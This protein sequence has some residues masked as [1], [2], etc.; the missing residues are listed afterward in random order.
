ML[1]I[2]RGR[3]HGLPSYNQT[4]SDLGLT[5][6]SSFADITSDTDLQTALASVYS[7]VNDV[8]VWVGGIAEDHLAGSSVGL[9]INTIL[10][11]QFE[12]LRD[13]DRFWFENDPFFTGDPQLLAELQATTL[14][15]IILRNTNIASLQSN[16]F[17]IPEPTT[18][19]L[20]GAGA[21]LLLR[22][23]TTRRSH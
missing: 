17:I 19:L 3:D 22:R 9:L 20:L 7:D 15:D 23:R 2:Q 14:A 5:V 21:M 18:L 8:D 6:A 13:G 12:R 4:L 1:N 11:D 16:V 10:A